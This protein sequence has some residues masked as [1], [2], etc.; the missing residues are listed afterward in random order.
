MI[1]TKILYSDYEI[2]KFP[3]DTIILLNKKGEQTTEIDLNDIIQ[4]YL[5]NH[6]DEYQFQR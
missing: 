5:E 3:W 4:E 2:I 1:Q 6:E